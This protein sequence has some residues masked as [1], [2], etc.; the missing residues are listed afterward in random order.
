MTRHDPELARRLYA[1][2]PGIS[3][4]RKHLPDMGESLHNAAIDLARDCTT[5]RCD[6]MLARL[7]GAETSL[8]HLRQKLMQEGGS[9]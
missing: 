1:C 2:K 7:K 6:Q 3:A 4:M 8:M 9:E 5:E